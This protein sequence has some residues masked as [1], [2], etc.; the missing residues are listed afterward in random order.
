MSDCHGCG[1]PLPPSR[2]GPPRKWCSER[3]RRASYSQPCPQCGTPMG[4]SDGRGPNA[5]ALCKHCNGL[6]AAARQRAQAEPMQLRLVALWAA[7]W[8]R[9]EIA[10]DLGMTPRSCTTYI[11]RLR[12]QGVPLPHRR[13]DMIANGQRLARVRWGR[14]NNEDD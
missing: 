14:E 8:T 7:G 5:P 1:I 10:A 4:G 13:P 11:G 12:A 9:G 2:G 3:C 6:A